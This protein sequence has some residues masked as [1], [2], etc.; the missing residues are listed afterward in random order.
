V[1]F[2]APLEAHVDMPEN[3]QLY[4][5]LG[6]GTSRSATVSMEKKALDHGP[7]ADG[8]DLNSDSQILCRRSHLMASSKRVISP[9]SIQTAFVRWIGLKEF[10]QIQAFK[11]HP[12][13]EA[14]RLR[15]VRHGRRCD[16][17]TRSEAGEVPIAV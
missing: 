13:L 10:D 11:S 16:Q 17:A 5:H 6:S 8:W 7:T 1:R 15:T 4:Q 9:S 14:T 2:R 3:V 12:N